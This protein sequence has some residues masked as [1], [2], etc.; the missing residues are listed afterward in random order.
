MDVSNILHQ[1]LHGRSKEVKC[2]RKLNMKKRKSA[3]DF[4]SIAYFHI[5]KECDDA[6]KDIFSSQMMRKLPIYVLYIMNECL[7]TNL[8]LRETFFF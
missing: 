7:K 4:L 8:S 1:Y 5:R 2:K 3:K 6:K